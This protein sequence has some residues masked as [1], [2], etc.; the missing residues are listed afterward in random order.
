M[1]KRYKNDVKIEGIEVTMD[2]LV[3]SRGLLGALNNS[4]MPAKVGMQVR[5]IV[6]AVN[7]EL[8]IYEETRKALIDKYAKKDDDGNPVVKDE[9][10]EIEDRDKFDEEI[11][12]AL[13][14]EVVLNVRRL[15]IDELDGIEIPQQVGDGV[16]RMYVPWKP[17]PVELDLIAYVLEDG[18]P[19]TD[20]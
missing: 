4:R 16:A 2:D 7:A 9:N 11:Q 8:E 5:R 3:R 6:K 20:S 12:E 15:G 1:G 14:S 13:E 19:A 18:D 10:Y 17:T